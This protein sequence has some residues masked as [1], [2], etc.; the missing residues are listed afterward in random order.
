MLCFS[1]IQAQNSNITITDNASH[2]ADVSSVLDVYSTT[3]GML[4]PR[5][6][7][8]QMGMISTPARGLLIFNTDVNSFYFYNGTSWEDLSGTGTNLWG[9]N[10]TGDLYVS[11]T[12]A[13][14]GIGT[15]S[16]ISKLTVKAPGTLPVDSKLFEIQDKDGFP[17]FTV[18]SEGVRI[19]VKDVNSKAASGGFAVGKYG[20]AKGTPETS[21]LIVTPD[22]TRVYM[23]SNLKATSGGFAVG[24]YGAAKGSANTI[25]YAGSD[26]TRVYTN[27]DGKAVSGGFAVGKYGAAKGTENYLHLTKE[28]Y[29][30]GH[31]SGEN[32]TT[33]VNNLFMGYESGFN[34]TI[35]IKNTFLGHLSGYNNQDGN[36]NIFIGDSAG[37]S[38]TE[39][40]NNIFIGVSAGYKT[41]STE[42]NQ[43]G[44]E[45]VFIGSY[46][47]YSNIDGMNNVYVGN[48][49][50][51]KNTGGLGNVFIGGF[52]GRENTKSNNTFV[53][54]AACYNNTTGANNTSIGAYS[55]TLNITGSRNVFIGYNAGYNETGSDK[56]YIENSDNSLPLI[57]GDFS[58]NFIQINGNQSVAG[59][60]L[61]ILS[62]PGTGTIPTNY[63]YQ[64]TNTASASKQYA[65]TVHDALWVTS[66]AWVD[67]ILTNNKSY[68]KIS[69][70][71][72]NVHEIKNSLE[73]ILN[74]ETELY[75]EEI[76]GTGENKGLVLKQNTIAYNKNSLLKQFDFLVLLDE[77]GDSYFPYSRMS[78]F[79]TQAIQEQQKIIEN[80][81]TKIDNLE[82]RIFELEKTIN[83]LVKH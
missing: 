43:Y 46:S 78:V 47:G 67:G 17:I 73:K 32:M 31:K 39:D 69:T 80:Q 66:N 26:S 6:N 27:T 42:G 28:N 15:S 76:I 53:G 2:T 20:A 40:E 12:D 59:T 9:V 34:N 22:S 25:L 65:F 13:N 64:G 41:H 29:F 44:D 5:M 45:N 23:E 16:P 4:V 21:Y 62:N 55:G 70:A 68:E 51:K 48:L 37:Y 49:T 72:A 75:T 1:V 81:N 11:D 63:V 30:I 18:T 10:G 33:G 36:K 8:V 7:T 14:I 54:G 50:G 58:N 79:L 82:N 60:Y 38:C 24:K 57:Y 61:Q 19:Y 74:L 3:K 77:N 71:K 35:G 83:D 52:T 56:L